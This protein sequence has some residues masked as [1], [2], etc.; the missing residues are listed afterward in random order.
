MWASCY[1][2]FLDSMLLEMTMKVLKLLQEAAPRIGRAIL[3]CRAQESAAV[4]V[5]VFSMAR[6][7]IVVMT[8][9]ERIKD[10]Q[11]TWQMHSIAFPLCILLSL[12]YWFDRKIYRCMSTW[13]HAL[14]HGN[15]NQI[16]PIRPYKKWSI[17]Q[18]ISLRIRHWALQILS[19]VIS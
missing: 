14:N 19:E 7:A 13:M 18:M 10:M 17:M 4:L 15:C 6:P 2:T 9:G 11:L 16:L 1:L 8:A 3:W 5:A 12:G